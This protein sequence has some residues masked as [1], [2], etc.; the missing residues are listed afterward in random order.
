MKPG[1]LE[2][3]YFPYTST[4]R[5]AFRIRFPRVAPDRRPTIAPNA[6]WVGLRFAGAEGNEELRWDLDTGTAQRLAS[7][8]Q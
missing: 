8:S 4:W 5:Q 3:T 1:A 7:A 2:R 6:H